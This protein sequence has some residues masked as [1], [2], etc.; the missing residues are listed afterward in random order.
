[1]SK[2]LLFKKISS[3]SFDKLLYIIWFKI[4]HRIF[5]FFEKCKLTVLFSRKFYSYKGSL[6]LS[7]K[8]KDAF[9]VYYK[10]C[11]ENVDVINVAN[12]ILDNK[13]V[14][15][16]NKYLIEETDWLIDPVSKN[17]WDGEVF[18]IDSKVSETNFGDVKFVMELNKMGFLVSLAHAYYLTSDKK[19]ILKIN[20]YLKG[21]LKTVKYERSVAN[22]SMLDISF[23]CFNL[24]QI[25][26]LCY[27]NVLF[28]NEV[29][30]VIIGILIASEKQIRKFSTPRWTKFSSGA[31]HTI[32][33]MVGLIVTQLWLEQFTNKSYKQF[34][35]KQ[36]Y[37]LNRSL[38]NIITPKGVY[39]EQSSHY[40]K[41]VTEFLV[42]LDI[43]IKVNENKIPSDLYKK[44]Y[45]IQ[46]LHYISTISYNDILP[47]FGDND[48]AKVLYPFYDHSYSVSHLKMYLKFIDPNTKINKELICEDSGQFAW[49]SK[50][51]NSVYVFTRAGKHSL[52]PLG[53]GSHA[54][55]DI[56]S[57]IVSVRNKPL[58]IDYGTYFYNSG[59]EIL[60][61]DRRTSNHNTISIDYIEQ[62]SLAGKWMYG[63]YPVSRILYDDISISDTVFSFKGSCTYSGRIHTRSVSYAFSEFVIIDE[64]KCND[65]DNVKV[66]FLLSPDIIGVNDSKSNLFLYR[67][68]VKIALIQFP[69]WVKVEIS[70]SVYHPS[71]GIEKTTTKITGLSTISGNQEIK[72]IIRII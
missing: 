17:K 69:D 67:E 38:E 29:F 65:D 37:Y 59:I 50:D 25:S 35:K 55:N 70:E 28:M 68:K 58:F 64:I 39:L 20:D 49:K 46:L 72:T 41:L 15:F 11:V 22:K 10:H 44:D 3:V 62:A 18:F 26:L 32:G 13:I 34:Y 14:L 23:R 45:L 61:N 52:L 71:Y 6:N 19:Y 9:E 33:E 48:G 5:I 1:M 57:L 40:S 66:N 31:N 53:S 56:L 27:N 7:F 63:S 21:W 4:Q 51:I 36:F 42:M 54:H 60:N 47:N 16:G 12:D 30:P 8:N 24:I 43:T 2:K